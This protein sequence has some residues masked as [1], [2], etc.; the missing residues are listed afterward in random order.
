MRLKLFSHH[1][2]N[3]VFTPNTSAQ[4]AYIER[5]DIESLFESNINIPGRQIILYGHSGSGKTTLTR[6]VLNKYQLSS[7]T[8]HCESQTTFEDLLINAFDQLGEFHISEYSSTNGSTINSNVSGKTLGL[9]GSVTA[10]SSIGTSERF[11]RTLPPQLTPQRLVNSLGKS[12]KIWIIEDFHKMESLEKKRLADILKIFVDSANTY[13]KVKVI[14]IGAVDTARELVELDPNLSNRVSELFVPLLS[15]DEIKSIIHRGCYIL[16][17]NMATSLVEKIVYYSNKLGAL[18]HQMCYDICYSNKITK[19][20]YIT[21]KLDDGK[22]KDAV[23]A[24][25]RTNSDTFKAVYD[26]TAKDKA[27][28]YILKTIINSGKDGLNTSEIYSRAKGKRQSFTFNQVKETLEVLCSPNYNILRYDANSL[29]YS[30]STP[31]WGAFLKMQFAIEKAEKQKAEN[32]KHNFH[33]NLID[34]NDIYADVYRALLN[35]LKYIK[36][37]Q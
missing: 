13:P 17:I 19:S 7:I 35:S 30:L 5:P 18:A 15:D 26:S 31:F 3:E 10:T 36:E 32:N 9:Q 37:S 33:L 14:C 6:Q 25:I 22:F 21:Q 20:K 8:S 34:Q 4:L 2:I 27:T 23:E 12:S 1:K 16:N 11:I 29:K 28:W 24:Y